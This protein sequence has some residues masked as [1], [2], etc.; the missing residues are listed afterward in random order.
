MG[1]VEI[2][3]TYDTIY[4]DRAT[5]LGPHSCPGYVTVQVP[6]P[7]DGTPRTIPTRIDNLRV[8][9]D[10]RQVPARFEPFR[11][12]PWDILN[13]RAAKALTSR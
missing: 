10:G 8:I 5:I 3:K 1:N 2:G 11:Y 6:D 4:G 7:W 12:V 9:V 13:Y